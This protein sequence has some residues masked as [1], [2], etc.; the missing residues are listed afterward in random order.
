MAYRAF[1]DPKKSKKAMIFQGF[2]CLV[3]RWIQIQ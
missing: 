2:L 3:G 1:M